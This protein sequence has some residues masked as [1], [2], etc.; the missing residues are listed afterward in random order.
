MEK[1]KE[2]NQILSLRL[3]NRPVDSLQETLGQWTGHRGTGALYFVAWF[4]KHMHT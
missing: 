2:A 3:G 4:Y 1:T